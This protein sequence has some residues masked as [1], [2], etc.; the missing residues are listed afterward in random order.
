ML[1]K[2]GLVLQR[3][4]SGY[5]FLKLDVRAKNGVITEIAYGLRP[6]EG[7]TQISAKDAFVVP[8]LVNAHVHSY[9][10][11]L[12]GTTQG[13]PLELWSLGT[14]ALGG[15]M[16][17]TEMAL[18]ARLGIAEM[19]RCGVTA[20]IDHI[21]HPTA[22]DAIAGEY[23]S[24]G[25]RAALAPMLH[26]R[27]DHLLLKGMREA[28]PREVRERLESAVSATLEERCGQYRLWIRKHHHGDGML[29]VLVGPNSPQ[30]C[31]EEL[32][33]AA[34][35]LAR[36]YGLGVHTHLL[37]TLWQRD[38]AE[39]E[40]DPLEKLERAGLLGEKTSLAHCVWLSGRQRDMLSQ[41]GCTV[42][43]NPAS[44]L[45]LGSGQAPVT[46]YLEDS[47]P[48]AFGSDGCNC[49]IGHNMLEI[50]RHAL[51]MQRHTGAWL[52]TDD[53]WESLLRCGARA[54]LLEERTGEIAIGKSADITV[55]E[56]NTPELMPR[57]EPAAQCIINLPRPVVRHSVINGNVVLKDG[58]ITAFDEQELYLELKQRGAELRRKFLLASKSAAELRSWYEKVF[59]ERNGISDD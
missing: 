59:F 12:K 20:C 51:L 17:E 24:A 44:N 16:D 7:E 30:R 57:I 5:V 32:L 2:D 14:V 55:W 40:G 29:S 8:G 35:E 58:V 18:S 4:E 9:S 49:G 23:R 53:A 22:V 28:L 47:I 25:F 50:A 10:N 56:A 31:T 39:A 21:P 52:S 36:E 1:I 45:F 42:I 33:F 46:K 19:L 37:E 27:S 11:L 3:T 48:V 54:M 26:D 34:G 6:E 43:H 38:T 15:C 41:Y 13:E